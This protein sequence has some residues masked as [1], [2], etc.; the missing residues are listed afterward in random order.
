MCRVIWEIKSFT[1][2]M[3]EVVVARGS[4]LP[5]VKEESTVE[6]WRSTAKEK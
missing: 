1:H 5:G 4:F 6:S 2:L 3:T